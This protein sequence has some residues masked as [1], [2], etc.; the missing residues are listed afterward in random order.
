MCDV[1]GT[2]LAEGD[3]VGNPLAERDVVGNPLAGIEM[4]EESIKVL[5]LPL[6]LTL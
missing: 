1:V 4:L 2:P 6:I 3:V 5:L